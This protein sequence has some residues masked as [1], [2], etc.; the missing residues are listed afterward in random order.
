MS[1]K[2]TQDQIQPA[3]EFM[4]PR[5]QG[6]GPYLSTEQFTLTDVNGEVI[7]RDTINEEEVNLGAI[8]A[9]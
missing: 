1:I 9:Q 6:D 7:L 4:A 2:L 8:G 5:F 3:N